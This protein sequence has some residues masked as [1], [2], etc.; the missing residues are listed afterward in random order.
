MTRKCDPQ[1]GIVVREDVK[2]G[3][4]ALAGA[5]LVLALT[6]SAHPAAAACDKETA[7]T[8]PGT[9]LNT[10]DST[11]A[12]G[13]VKAGANEVKRAFAETDRYLELVRQ[14]FPEPVGMNV[15]W[16]KVFN[17]N[18]DLGLG[19]RAVPQEVTVSF[20]THFCDGP[21]LRAESVSRPPDLSLEIEV[22]N[23]WNLLYLTS[24]TLNGRP[25]YTLAHQTGEHRGFESFERPNA[26]GTA[27]L[28]G[29]RVYSRFVLLTRPGALPFTYVTRRQV[30]GQLRADVRKVREQAVKT[31]PSIVPVR[32]AAEQEAALK[33]RIEEI[34]KDTYLGAAAKAKRI[35]RLKADYR[36][37]EQRQG[38][39]V[40]NAGAM[41]DAAL[42][43]LD[44]V[45]RSFTPAQLGEPAVLQPSDVH[46]NSVLANNATTWGFAQPKIDDHYCDH[47]CRHGQ[48]LVTIDPSYADPRLPRTAP[49]FFLMALQWRGVRGSDARDPF[50]ERIAA[51]FLAKF[52]YDKLASLLGR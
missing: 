19:A 31:A 15:R 18:A 45:E 4:L 24:M 30:L 38:A 10:G 35:E 21:V 6:F 39:T 46:P 27:R 16:Y 34:E 33:R 49:Q 50:V 51:D 14:V 5:L 12:A 22:N 48:R 28:G 29:V 25:V 13:D 44:E 32:A 17:A 2:I 47:L 8:T 42:R 52:D 40:A 20:L 7:Q 23:F 37:D 9:W 3:L 1:E 36:T 26:L 41:Y 43:R 11:G